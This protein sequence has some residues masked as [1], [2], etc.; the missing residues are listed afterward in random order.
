MVRDMGFQVE[1]LA[2]GFWFLGF[3]VW[4]LVLQEVLAR[5]SRG[6]RAPPAGGSPVFKADRLWYHSNLDSRVIK[7]RRRVF[8]WRRILWMS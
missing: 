6:G 1:R 5:G 3:A 7:K 2:S 8:T 4:C